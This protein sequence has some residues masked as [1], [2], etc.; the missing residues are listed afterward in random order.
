[1]ARAGA[2]QEEKSARAASQREEVKNR[3]ADFWKYHDM[4]DATQTARDKFFKA[5]RANLLFSNPSD[6]TLLGLLPPALRGE[7]EDTLSLRP[8][9]MR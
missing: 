5:G 6:A 3:L 7:N 2:V 8:W 4:Q 1:M 9:W